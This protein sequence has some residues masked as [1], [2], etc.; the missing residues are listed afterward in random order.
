MGY[1]VAAGWQNGREGYG[2][3]LKDRIIHVRDCLEPVF[4]YK[5]SLYSPIPIKCAISLTEKASE[6]L[7]GVIELLGD[8]V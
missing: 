4:S 7:D 8:I 6:K 2:Y 3:D 5:K 1:G